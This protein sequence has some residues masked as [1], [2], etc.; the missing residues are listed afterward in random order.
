MKIDPISIR[1]N[2]QCIAR[3]KKNI[4]AVRNS[5]WK[6]EDKD[7]LEQRYK[8]QLVRHQQRIYAQR[9]QAISNREKKYEDFKTQFIPR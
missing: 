4:E 8:S 7:V 5:Q 6:Q 9:K 3:L 1:Y 2:E